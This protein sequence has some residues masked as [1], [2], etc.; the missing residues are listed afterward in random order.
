[1][2]K[3]KLIQNIPFDGMRVG[4]GLREILLIK[5]RG[6]LWGGCWIYW[7]GG[8]YEV[9]NLNFEFSFKKN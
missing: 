1:M 2:N 3:L 8:F 6:F 5:I 9:W 4:W 7:G